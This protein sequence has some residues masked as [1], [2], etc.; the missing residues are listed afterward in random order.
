MAVAILYFLS[1]IAMAKK[2]TE[3]ILN[4]EPTSTSSVPVTQNEQVAN[5]AAAPALPDPVMDFFINQP[6]NNDQKILVEKMMLEPKD[7]VLVERTP[8]ETP[9]AT[10]E[11]AINGMVFRFKKGVYYTLP[12][13][14]VEHIRRSQNQTEAALDNM[15]IDRDEA[16]KDALL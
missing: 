10:Y 1:I 9:G 6:K 3:D 15:R 11:G 12:K 16:V 7:S 4:D 13:S 5:V 8:G 14:L 2:I